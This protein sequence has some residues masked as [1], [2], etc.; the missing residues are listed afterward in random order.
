MHKR[1]YLSLIACTSLMAANEQNL[2]TIEVTEQVNTKVINEVSTKEVKN[3]DLAE[4]LAK[5]SPSISLI[6][7]SGIANDII[8]RGQKRDNIRVTIDDAVVC[9]A[10][11][12]R[13]DPPT[14]HVITTM[15]D[16]VEIKEGPFDV[17]EFGN[18]SGGVKI[19]TVEPTKELSGEIGTTIGSYGYKKGVV[20]VS[21]GNDTVR[22][23]VTY[24]Q[25]ESDQ[26]EDGDG[27][28]LST[29]TYNAVVGTPAAGT[30]YAPAYRDMKAYEKKSIMAKVA[31]NVADNQ[32]I[33]VS[34]T[35]NRS[36]NVLYPSSKMDARYDDSNIYNIKYTAKDL[37]EL[38]KNLEI[39]AYK[40]DVDHPMDTRFRVAGATTFMTNH[41]TTD[42]YGAK[43]I[44]TFDALNREFQ[45]GLDTSKRNWDGRYYNSAGADLGKSINDTDTKNNALFIKCKNE[46]SKELTLEVGLRYDDTTIDTAGLQQDND[47]NS[48]SGNIVATYQPNEN[49]KYFAGIGQSNRVPD[50]REL[51]N[52]GKKATP[53]ATTQML[54]GTPS[55]N[56]VKNREIDL[57]V[58]HQY[59]NAKIKGKIFYSDLKDYIYYNSTNMANKF[60]NIDATI[61]GLELS[62]SYFI[63]DQF[64]LDAGYTYKRGKKDTQ[65]T[66]AAQTDKDLADITPPKFTLA[67]TYDHD[68]NTNAMVEF[69]HVNKWSKFDSDN[70]EQALDS[71]NVV[72]VKAQ[73]TFAK[74]FEL[75][76]GIDNLFDKTY[77]VSNTY[78]DLTLLTDGTTNETLLLNEPG[79]YAYASLKYKF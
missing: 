4:A 19:K 56:E 73:T 78:Y 47:Y 11:P 43:I 37:G 9:G 14:S 62:A 42:T 39:K 46:L 1:I 40:T 7:R 57:G 36:D 13:M 26:Y 55:L 23:L 74:N 49:T 50:A 66:G 12:N 67:L 33:E 20:S 58:E 79:R 75:T 6:R 29:Q 65:P 77:A 63:N 38:S 28:S 3:A 34:A 16:S 53:A 22:A 8:L 76:V 17:S 41:L 54:I 52:L 25:E 31:A 27:N 64:T 30:Q 44:N 71:Y 18:L 5:K 10:C 48:L 45:I 69:V 70:G 21:G 60:E 72:N 51:Y 59:A 24:S 15:V 32:E 68:D 35:Q 2:G 61:Y